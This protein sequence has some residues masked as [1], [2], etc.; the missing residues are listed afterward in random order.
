MYVIQIPKLK[1]HTHIE[2]LRLSDIKMSV[3]RYNCLHDILMKDRERYN[4]V[5]IKSMYSIGQTN[6]QLQ[7]AYPILRQRDH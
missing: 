2:P 1:K 3:K 7:L 4:R 6:Q 5:N